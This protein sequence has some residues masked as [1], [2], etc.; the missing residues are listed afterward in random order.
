MSALVV[1]LPARSFGGHERMLIEWLGR[2]KARHGLQV[3]VHGAGNEHLVRACEAAGLGAPR[4]SYPRHGNPVGDFLVTW[5]LLGRVAPQLPVLFAPNVVQALPLQWLAAF[6]RR[7]RVVGYVPMAYPASL[8]GYR[9][10]ALR[11]WI[12]R[13]IARR[14]DMWIT[15]SGEQQQLLLERWNAPPPVFVVPNSL[16]LA[17]SGAGEA[18]APAG[19]V[20]RVLYAGRFDPNQKG[21]DWLCARLRARRERWMGRLRFTFQGDGRFAEELLRL[22]HEL[23][24][25]H[26]RVRG[27]GD[28]R[29]AMAEADV[30]LLPSRFEGVPLVALEATHYGLPVVA[31][32]G[33]GVGAFAA[34]ACL[35]EF[36]DDEAMLAALLALREPSRRAA[37]LAHA[38][39]RLRQSVCPTSFRREIERVTA[40]LRRMSA[41]PFLR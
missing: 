27:W 39:S 36:G 19:G 34:P 8:M 18:A 33:A 21:L 11:D 28:V 13:R 5:R 24:E 31:T 20:L 12:A 15:I 40:A 25:E 16:T 37:A 7:R 32:R 10:G 14:V 23:G 30:V 4:A 22:S 38:R 17:D 35:F 1:L 41:A 9:A 29:A 26:V 3:E 2:A 6:L